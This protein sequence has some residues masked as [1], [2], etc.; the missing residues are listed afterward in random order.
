MLSIFHLLY[1]P[2]HYTVDAVPQIF[3]TATCIVNFSFLQ[4]DGLAD[5][6]FKTFHSEMLPLVQILK[7]LNLNA[8]EGQ[9]TARCKKLTLCTCHQM[10]LFSHYN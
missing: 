8:S 1:R 3:L 2:Q 7:L 6:A 5:H 10:C 4:I 9:N